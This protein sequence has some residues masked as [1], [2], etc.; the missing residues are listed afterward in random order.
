MLLV[1]DA[2]AAM[3]GQR[4]FKAPMS[5]EEALDE[6]RAHAG[7]QFDPAVVE[8][9]AELAVAL[10][11]EVADPGRVVDLGHRRAAEG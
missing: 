1:A 10:E 3:T 7:K 2:Y 9:M 11:I 6:L 4:P 5:S 8:A